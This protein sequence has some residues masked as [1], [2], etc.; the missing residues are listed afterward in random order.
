MSTYWYCARGCDAWA[1]TV[2]DK[3]PFHR[4]PK[5]A[6][7]MTPLVPRGVAAKV[8]ARERED[9]VGSEL[10]QTDANGRPIMSVVTTRDEGQDCAVFAPLA[11]GSLE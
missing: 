4:C 2:D 9:Y 10:V 7:I 8:E 6:L 3:K 5:L 1:R 11:T